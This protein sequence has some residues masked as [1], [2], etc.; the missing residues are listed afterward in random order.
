MNGEGRHAGVEAVLRKRQLLSDGI[1]RK[2]Q[3]RRPLRTHRS[4]WLNG[5]DTTVDGLIGTCTSANVEHGPGAA[6]RSPD[7][8]FNARVRPAVLRV[9]LADQSVV[10]VPGAAVVMS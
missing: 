5:S 8:R 2:R 4:R 6:E 9:S 10:C 1:D 3:V 7:R